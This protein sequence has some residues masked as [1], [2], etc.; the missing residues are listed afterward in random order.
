MARTQDTVKVAAVQAAPVA[1]DLAASL[2]K[3]EALTAEAAS[4]G[5]ELVAFPE[6]FLSAYPWR[7]AFDATV[8][9]REPR[10]RKWFVKYYDSAIAIAS[11]EFDIL[12]GIARDNKVNLSI[13]IVEKDEA[14]LY[15][16]AVLIGTD[17]TLLSRHRKLVPTGAERLI[18][19]RGSGDSLKVV[20]VGFGKIGG[21]I[22]WENYMPA[23]RL[24]L[25]QRGVEIYIAPTA[26]DP[27]T[28]A[29]TMQ[30]IAKEGRCFVISINQFCKVSDF[31]SDYPP[32]TLEH[33]DRNPEGNQWA[34][35][36]ILNHG[37]SCIVGPM[38]N[39][40]AEAVRDKQEIVYA[41]LNLAD[42]TEAKMDFDVVGSYSRPDI[43][44][45]NVNTK[46]GVNVNFKN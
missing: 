1:F 16:T 2:K 39:F 23:A 26:D 32:F 12:C 38:G 15:C 11:P 14:T 37:G 3:V 6:A 22:C 33:P 40:L 21:L 5:A 17:G 13:G 44:T 41:T 31:P 7:Y 8:G 42:L 18:W 36:D 24:A 46:P 29:A 20:D 10:G 28:W 4:Q 43:F 30:H 27:V 35:D 9:N 45:L 19:G 34:Q 25:Y